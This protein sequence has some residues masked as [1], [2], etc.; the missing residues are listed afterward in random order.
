MEL[1]T[2]SLK[3]ALTRIT[4]QLPLHIGHMMSHDDQ[5]KFCGIC[6]GDHHQQRR[7]AYDGRLLYEG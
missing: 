4:K 2:F 7:R 5:V 6:L 1:P 3:G